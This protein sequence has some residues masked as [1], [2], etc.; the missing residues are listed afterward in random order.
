MTSS[1]NLYTIY[2]IAT[3]SSIFFLQKKNYNSIYSTFK[4]QQNIQTI[5]LS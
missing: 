2:W 1:H 4:N 3:F 5:I